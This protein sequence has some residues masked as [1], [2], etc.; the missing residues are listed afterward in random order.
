MNNKVNITKKLLNI[1]NKKVL[2]SNSKIENIKNKKQE[3]INNKTVLNNNTECMFEK[4]LK[5]RLEGGQFRMLNE[6]MYKNK[7]LDAEQVERY[8]T[9]YRNQVKKW[10]IDPNT[11]VLKELDEKLVKLNFLHK[12]TK[13]KVADLGCGDV[14]KYKNYKFTCKNT[15]FDF[16]DKYVIEDTNSA[17]G[18]KENKDI[19]YFNPVIKCDL[20]DIKIKSNSYDVVICCLSLMMD[21]ITNVMVE[22]NRILK[23]GGI[24]IF[25]EVRSRINSIHNFVNKL[26]KYGYKAENVNSSNKYF[27]II[28]MVKIEE[29]YDYTKENIN[30]TENISENI[31]NTNNTENINNINNTNNTEDNI[32]ECKKSKKSLLISKVKNYM[33]KKNNRLILKTCN[34]KK[35]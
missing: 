18:K 34:Y 11:M 31:N 13:I 15:E 6:K 30:N 14:S 16:Y 1:K 24:F 20:T 19:N 27:T 8:H 32:K 28:R 21:D 22:I 35:R 23:M 29:V 25:A 2:N 33:K 10:P 4:V 7:E 26:C 12:N 17:I 5:K 9:F 3:N